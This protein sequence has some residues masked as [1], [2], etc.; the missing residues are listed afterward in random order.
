MNSGI[1]TVSVCMATYNGE[2]YIRQ[3]VESILSQLSD[4]DE[5]IISDDY[6]DDNTLSIV[7]SFGD[8]RV[9]LINGPRSGVV[10]NFN[11]ALIHAK[12]DI[13]FLADQ[14]DVWA[15]NKVSVFLMELSNPNVS[16]V[17]SDCTVVDSNLNT[18]KDS[19][20]SLRSSRAGLI[21][22][23]FKNSYLGCCMAF[24]RNVLNKALPFPDNTPMHDWWLGLI[25]EICGDVVF[26][27]RKLL[28]YR[29][30][31][32]NASSTSDSSPNS[33]WG[34]VRFRLIITLNL[35]KRL[36]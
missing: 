19:F 30:H 28:L 22:N 1:C 10:N 25:A 34:K 8:S 23:L 12:G 24:K 7:S 15:E 5:L 32:N 31:G 17:V 2:P 26:V 21:N 4:R 18:L 6:S 9:K 35:F 27:Q 33:F 3:Q 13:I 20:F 36:K 11:N 16:L 29:R 14:D